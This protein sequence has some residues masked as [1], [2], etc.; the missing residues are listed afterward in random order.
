MGVTRGILTVGR[1]PAARRM[2]APAPRG[3]GTKERPPAH[4]M[5]LRWQGTNRASDA[6]SVPVVHYVW[7]AATS[8]GRS[9]PVRERTGGTT[10]GR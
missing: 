7:E 2:R 6:R 8:R 3:D 4:R 1:D 9:G 5:H 10:A